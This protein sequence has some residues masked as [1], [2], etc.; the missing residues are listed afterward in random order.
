MRPRR[1]Y[2]QYNKQNVN[3]SKKNKNKTTIQQKESTVKDGDINDN[4]ANE[5][6]NLERNDEEDTPNSVMECLVRNV[7]SITMSVTSLE[8]K[9]FQ[10]EKKFS[11]MNNLIQHLKGN[12]K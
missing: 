10:S 3:K 9:I 12:V 2:N 8:S 1:D 6:Q 7:E 4:A 5:D 11:I